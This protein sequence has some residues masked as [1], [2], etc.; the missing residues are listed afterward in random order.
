[1]A[2]SSDLKLLAK[3]LLNSIRQF[4]H[5]INN[6][7]CVIS[8]SVGRLDRLRKTDT[9]PQIEKCYNEISSATDQIMEI[10]KKLAPVRAKLEELAN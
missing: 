2:D 7:L 6:P 5:D 10:L 1:M 3:E 8:L 9:N 4:Q